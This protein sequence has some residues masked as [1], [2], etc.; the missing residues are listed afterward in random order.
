MELYYDNNTRQFSMTK[1]D[2]SEC[3]F[4]TYDCDD[5]SHKGRA[6]GNNPEIKRGGIRLS[7]KTNFYPSAP[8]MEYIH[9]II[10]YNDMLLLPLS[11]LI[12]NKNVS[13]EQLTICQMR[14][15][16]IYN[17]YGYFNW[18]PIL[19]I[20]CKICNHPESWLIEECDNLF[21]RLE[22]E[23]CSN[24]QKILVLEKLRLYEDIPFIRKYIQSYFDKHILDFDYVKSLLS[25]IIDCKKSKKS[26]DLKEK[27]G[28]FDIIWHYIIDYF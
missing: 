28:N 25:E 24:E 17:K 19:E 18:Q 6:K 2:T 22:T 21:Q 16:D 4:K 3:V 23:N 7:I 10:H 12:D 5:N 1:S 13:K 14:P 15:S 27:M 9:V 8:S 26:K 20:I 11:K